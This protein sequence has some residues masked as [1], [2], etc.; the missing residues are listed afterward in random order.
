[1]KMRK[2][3]SVLLVLC[4]V[5]AG[6]P[7]TANAQIVTNSNGS[8][9]FTTFEDLK[10]LAADAYDEEVYCYYNGSGDLVIDEKTLVFGEVGLSGEIRSV[11]QAPLRV[12]EAQKLGFTRVILPSACVR[13]VGKAEGIEL[14][15]VR[16]VRDLIGALA[17]QPS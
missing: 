12:R 16:N 6:L 15:G 4:M 1:M 5:A 2:L 7:M 3:L 17:V 13:S 9:S 14:V 8:I 10:T 11:S